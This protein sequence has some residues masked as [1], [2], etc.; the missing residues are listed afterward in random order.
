MKDV[1]YFDNAAT[2]PLSAAALSAMTETLSTIYGNPSST[3]ATGREAAR[4]LREAR[5]EI[6]TALATK[7]QYI[8]FT[9]GGTESD[10][11]AIKGYALAHQDQGKHIIS[12]S[13]EHHAVLETLEYL[14]EN[15]GF[16]I[17]LIKPE[18]NAITAQ[19]IK[20]A[21]RPDTILVSTMYANNETGYILP[22]KEIGEI[23][24]DHPAA[25]HV[26]AVQIMGKLPIHPEELG[27]DMLSAAGHKFHGPK[28]VGFL[29]AKDVKLTKLLHG[30]SQEDKRRAGTENLPGIVG[31]AKAL[32]ENLAH[33]QANLDH[34]QKV[35][36]TILENLDEGSYYLNQQE[37]HLPHILN[38]GFSGQSNDS[39]LLR[40]DLAGVAVSTGSACTAGAIE[41]SH[42]LA[43][44]Y[45]EDSPKLKESI[46]ISLSEL[47]T[48]EEALLFT[49]KL[50]DIIG[51]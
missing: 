12:T 36:D 1:I 3:H 49:Q 6:A 18:N 30:G 47:N 38:I 35:A 45:G 42:V 23:L 33:W 44:F 22:I 10:N 34:V 31:M 20:D 26:D 16:E 14:E 27:I 50:K 25:F 40:L 8:Y 32:T 5:Q 51:G 17:T 43:S 19:Q 4:V 37:P 13:I 2:T 24:A 39:L 41:P 11:T 7:P 9:A 46:R 29:Y 28:G 15:F 48:Q 21:L